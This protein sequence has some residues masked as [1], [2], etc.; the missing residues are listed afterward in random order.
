MHVPS[1][2][3]NIVIIASSFTES[4]FRPYLSTGAGLETLNPGEIICVSNAVYG[5]C[6]ALSSD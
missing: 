3:S 5:D 6:V 4:A 1:D 2:L